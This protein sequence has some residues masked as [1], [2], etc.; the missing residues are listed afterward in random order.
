METRSD[1]ARRALALGFFPALAFNQLRGR[2]PWTYSRYAPSV[3][4]KTALASAAAAASM[5]Y[6]AYR[7]SK[8][9]RRRRIQRAARRRISRITR[10]LYRRSRRSRFLR[11]RRT[12]GRR[13]FQRV[14]RKS[15]IKPRINNDYFRYTAKVKIGTFSVRKDSVGET[16]HNISF[17]AV[18]AFRLF[19]RVPSHVYAFEEFKIGTIRWSIEP[20]TVSTSNANCRVKGES[21]PYCTVSRVHVGHVDVGDGDGSNPNYHSDPKKQGGQATINVDTLRTIPGQ[22]KFAIMS[23][24]PVILYSRPTAVV[25]QHMFEDSTNPTVKNYTVDRSLGWLPFTDDAKQQ[26]VAAISI[27]RPIFDS[28]SEVEVWFDVHAEATIYF[29]GYTTLHEPSV[30]PVP[31]D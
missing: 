8:G 19:D 13:F 4:G 21:L 25:Q 24:R 14:G 23:K 5:A 7:L 27:Y 17:F 11:R 31:I 10:R 28:T 16:Q 20:R 22:K 18:N 12:T 3:I 6:G 1:A 29:R 30:P 26:F 9:F 15:S 2:G